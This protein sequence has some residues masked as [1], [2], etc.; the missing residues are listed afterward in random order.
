MKNR[1]LLSALLTMVFFCFMTSAEAQ[2][3]KS[4]SSCSKS[5]T[6]QTKKSCNKAKSSCTKSYEYSSCSKYK[7]SNCG[8]K[9]QSSN[10]NTLNTLVVLGGVA[11]DNDNPSLTT[12]LEF[13]RQVGNNLGLGLLS[14][15]AFADNSTVKVGIPISY[16]LGKN[17]K[18]SASPLAAFQQK[19]VTNTSG[20]T[21][22]IT[23][24]EGKDWNMSLGARAGVSY[25]MNVG[26][27]IFAP[28][29]RIDYTDS[30]MIP[31]VGV[32]VGFGF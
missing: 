23:T 21:D 20:N 30:K 18:V 17:V 2:C 19:D 16:H 29:A 28:T 1:Y 9:N 15:V 14:E 25:L 24:T 10:W 26:G 27:M 8:K 7:K 32:N 11:F 13:E 6:E 22:D 4:K 3:T 12:G 31:S 5:K